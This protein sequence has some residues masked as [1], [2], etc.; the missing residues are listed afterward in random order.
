[1]VVGV[2]VSSRVG[3]VRFEWV[4][5]PGT[6]GAGARL[7]AF[8]QDE[9]FAQVVA[10]CAVGDF[11]FACAVDTPGFGVDRALIAKPAAGVG[12]PLGFVLRVAA[13]ARCERPTCG[14]QLWEEVVA[15]GAGAIDP[16][17]SVRSTRWCP[18]GSVWDIG[19]KTA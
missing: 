14:P 19:W 9:H 18:Q 4:V 17:G 11:L 12:N 15:V 2:V 8:E 13:P 5:D 1:M 10:P 6:P 16:P 3:V 7:G